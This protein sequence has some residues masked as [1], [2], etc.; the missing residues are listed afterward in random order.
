AGTRSR[1]SPC[2]R[3]PRGSR[4]SCARAAGAQRLAPASASGRSQREGRDEAMTRSHETRP[5]AQRAGW[6]GGLLAALLL[7]LLGPAAAQPGTVLRL[8]IPADPLMN[9]ILG[10]DAA[11]VPINRFFFNALTRPDPETFEPRPDLATSW[12]A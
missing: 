1:T 12:E 4:P 6:R 8:A 11:A 2:S 9:P 10:T 5:R 3:T 7:A